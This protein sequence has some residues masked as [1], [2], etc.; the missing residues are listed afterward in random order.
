MKVTV[1]IPVKKVYEMKGP[2]RVQDI[3]KELGLP[4]ESV[5]VIYQQDLLTPDAVAYTHLR[6][7]E[8]RKDL[9]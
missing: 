6:E 8:T 5:I 4:Y 9:E 1:P 7:H 3:L 2:K